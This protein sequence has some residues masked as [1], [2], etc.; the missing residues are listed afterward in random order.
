M[1]HVGECQ[2]GQ[3]NCGVLEEVVYMVE[4]VVLQ[5]EVALELGPDPEVAGLV[6]GVLLEE[7]REGEQVEEQ[8]VGPDIS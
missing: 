1:G 6:P 3:D 2:E 4:V 8:V 7:E 5:E